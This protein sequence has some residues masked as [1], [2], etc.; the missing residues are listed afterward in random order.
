MNRK[1]L[2]SWLVGLVLAIPLLASPPAA[3]ADY[4]TCMDVCIH[5][6]GSDEECHEVCSRE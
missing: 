2:M 6:D 4:A 1:R 5:D 3:N